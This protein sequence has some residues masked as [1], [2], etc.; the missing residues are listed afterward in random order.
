MKT[1]VIPQVHIAASERGA[2]EDPRVRT[3]FAARCEASLA[4]YKRT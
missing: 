1:D 4:A 2:A 3:D